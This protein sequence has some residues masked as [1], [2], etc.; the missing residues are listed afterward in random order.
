MSL[1]SVSWMG[2]RAK[3]RLGSRGREIRICTFVRVPHRLLHARCEEKRVHVCSV[4]L[5]T[6]RKPFLTRKTNGETWFVALAAAKTT[7]NAEKKTKFKEKYAATRTGGK[8]KNN[9]TI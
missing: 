3:R 6:V 2:P 9:F 8:E 1:G 5:Y 4:I 7:E